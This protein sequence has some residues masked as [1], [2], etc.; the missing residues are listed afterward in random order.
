MQ[1]YLELMRHVDEKGSER[2][3]RTGTGIKSVFGHQMR[4]DL[5]KG[6]PLLTTKKVHW[7]SVVYEL[8]WLLSGDTNIK[9][10][11]D[12]GIRIWDEWADEKGELG[13]V[14]GKQW[15][16]W[17]NKEGEVIDQ[18][19]TAI[20]AIKHNPTSRRIIVNA[21]NVGELEEM[22][23]PP[24]HMMFQFFVAEGKLSC[25][26]YQRSCDVFLGLPFN[27]A[28]YALLTHMIA[29]QC[30]LEVGEFVW[31]GGDVHLYSNHA[32]QTKEQLSREP[33]SLCE[34]KIHRKP[35]SINDYTFEDFELIDYQAHPLIKGKVAV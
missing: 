3:D 22:A 10:L 14:Y 11:K 32:E 28:S 29:Q 6:F 18:I 2:M 16:R 21:W 35:H 34:L 1:Q 30:E 13:S 20:D 24:C 5:Q 4:F 8:L 17:E 27:I 7:K 9:F 25:Q 31:T 33:Y 23:L 26:L 15:R 19:Q 12:N